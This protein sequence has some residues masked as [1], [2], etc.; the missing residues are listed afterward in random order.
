MTIQRPIKDLLRTRLGDS[1]VA[2]AWERARQRRDGR[3]RAQKLGL[4]FG[5][6]ALA[7]TALVLWLGRAPAPL[8]LA[9]RDVIDILEA[10]HELR[11]VRMNDGSHIRLSAGT[12]L[13]TVANEGGVFGT[14]LIRGRA[15]FEVRP[16]GH[17]RW[18]IHAG[19]VT[20]EVV[21]THFIV[22]R[23]PASVWV[24]VSRGEVTVHGE[25]IAGGARRLGVGESLRVAAARMPAVK[26]VGPV[27]AEPVD[28]PPP[29]DEPPDETIGETI[30]E[31][32][33]ETVDETLDEVTPPAGP[34]QIAVRRLSGAD[35]H[36]PEVVRRRVRGQPDVSFQARICVD[37]QGAVSDVAVLQGV[38]G[39]NEALQATLRQWRYEPQPI[40]V[41][42]VTQLIFSVQ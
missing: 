37:K 6:A 2:A 41:C 26:T 23:E 31:T 15:E 18:L 36:L 30:G 42:F 27:A 25:R 1:E 24:H 32:I 13:D 33:D 20:V 14:T 12:R 39:A 3:R 11:T 40:P 8:R 9:N 28:E 4:A 22:K 34:Y 29:G 5:G 10:Q 16:G 21:G 35:P 38:D 19:D 17:R 7:L